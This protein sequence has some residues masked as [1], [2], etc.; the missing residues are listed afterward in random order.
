[1]AGQGPASAISETDAQSQGP[2]SMSAAAASSPGVARHTPGRHPYACPSDDSNDDAECLQGPHVAKMPNPCPYLEK[3]ILLHAL[4]AATT[5]HVQTTQHV[6]A[7]ALQSR[8][9]AGQLGTNDFETGG[10]VAPGSTR[11]CGRKPGAALNRGL[12]RCSLCPRTATQ[13]KWRVYG[14]LSNNSAPHIA[15]I[16]NLNVPKPSPLSLQAEQTFARSRAALSASPRCA[17]PQYGVCRLV[18][19]LSAKEGSGFAS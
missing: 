2:G 19:R 4:S 10:L 14:L 9:S 1:M 5:K 15:P 11:A 18:I 12:R 16:G 7:L 6:V 17:T 3:G 8:G 13:C